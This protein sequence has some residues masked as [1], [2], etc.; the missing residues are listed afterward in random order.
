MSVVV[1]P[2]TLKDYLAYDDGTDTRY[3]LVNGELVP[4]PPESRLNHRIVSFLFAYFLKTGVPS[5]RLSIGTQIAVS[6]AR[7][8]ARQPDFVVL[9]EAAAAAL[10]G[11]SSDLLTYDMPPPL[12]VVEVVSPG[13]GDRDYRHKRSEYAARCIPEYWIIDPTAQKVTVL[14]WVDGLYEEQV[15]VGDQAIQSPHWS[16]LTLE[17]A[18]VLT[19]GRG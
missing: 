14:A 12:L 18:M 6:G 11:A 17:A 5:D 16:P 4:M 15:Y 2:M 8:T 7:A 3:E 10:E 1:K 9:S 19:A 13:Q